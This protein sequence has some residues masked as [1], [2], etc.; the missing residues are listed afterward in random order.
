MLVIDH[1]RWG[2]NN[3]SWVKARPLLKEVLGYT[4]EDINN[5]IAVQEKHFF[6]PFAV[7]VT[8][9]QAIKILQP[10]EDHGLNVF[11]TE[12]DDKAFKIITHSWEFEWLDNI[13]SND[14]PKSHYYNKPVITTE[15]KVDPFNPPT[16]DNHWVNIDLGLE[17]VFHP[18][19]T[20]PTI[21]CPYCKS[22]NTKK[23][24]GLSK[25]VNVGLFGIFALGKTTKQWHCNKCG[26]DF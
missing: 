26:S 25:A 16:F 21:T 7:D 5:F 3:D 17:K 19:N 12:Y 14:I 23:I 2:R 6:P 18:S 10:F 13:V 9:E 4:D 24:S 15:Q 8:K 11:A 1:A 22:T 20:V